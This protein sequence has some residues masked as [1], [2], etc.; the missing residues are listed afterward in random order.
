MQANS[1]SGDAH[2][3][4]APPA[5]PLPNRP[6]APP[7]WSTEELLKACRRAFH[8][9]SCKVTDDDEAAKVPLPFPAAHATLQVMQALTAVAVTVSQSGERP[10]LSLGEVL[11][12]L[13]RPCLC[14]AAHNGRLLPVPRLQRG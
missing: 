14:C 7:A 1:F 11:C 6:S 5:L 2:T 9:F 4:P 12:I 8:Y 10:P 3:S 13:C